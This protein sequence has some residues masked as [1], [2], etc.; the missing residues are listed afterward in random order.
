MQKLHSMQVGLLL[1]A[2]GSSKQPDKAS[3]ALMRGFAYIQAGRHE[4]AL[5]DA[6]V[7]LAYGSKG[8]GQQGVC[9]WPWAHSLHS[10]A[11]EGLQDNVAAAL[12]M[13]TAHELDPA[14]ADHEENLERLMRRVPLAVAGV[15]E[16]EGS[17]GLQHWLAEEEER[18]KPEFLKQRPKY[19]Y[20]YEWMKQRIHA[21]HPALPEPVMDKLL[22]MPANDLD[23]ILQHKE[24]TTWKVDELMEVLEQGGPA[25]LEGYPVQGLS[26]EQVKK[27]KGPNLVGLGMGPGP[28]PGEGLLEHGLD[29]H[30][31]LKLQAQKQGLLEGSAH[32]L[33]PSVDLPACSIVDTADDS[34]DEQDDLDALIY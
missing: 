23:L 4:Q 2:W 33:R 7:V 22:T 13:Q 34:S 15:L 29:R 11:L 17:L 21:T 18:K 27:L 16:A 31:Q 5:K 28:A 30:E 20:Y 14:C 8:S 25:L 3:L 24:G 26:W 32:E 10:A 1:T 19:Y 12:A 6:R 9:V